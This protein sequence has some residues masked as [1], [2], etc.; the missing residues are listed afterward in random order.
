MSHQ[1]EHY[2]PVT[3]NYIAWVRI[4]SLSATVST[5]I[6]MYYGN[7]AIASN[8]S[9]TATWSAGYNGVWHLHNDFLDASGTGNNG[10]NNG[11]TDV[12]P[13]F[14]ADGQNFTDPNHWIELP[15]HPNIT[16]SF[17]STAWFRSSDVT[18]TGQRIICD[19][20]TNANGCWAISL[21]DPGSGRLRF[22]IR[23]LSVV[24]HDTGN[25]IANNTWY[26][27]AVVFN[28]TTMTKFLYVNGALIVSG[29]VTGTLGTPTGNASI[30]GEVAA[31][32][33]ANR[34][35]GDIDE[36]RTIPSVLSADWIAAEYNNQNSPSGFYTISGQM[37]ATDLCALLPV[38]LINFTAKQAGAN[39]IELDWTTASENNNDYFMIEKS[40][41]GVNW[42][43]IGT[44]DG[45]GNT[46]HAINYHFEDM[47]PYYGNNYYRLKQVDF[48]GAFEYSVVAKVNFNDAQNQIKIF[49]NPVNDYV[50][51]HFASAPQS[52]QIFNHGIEVTN[53]ITP[54]STHGNFLPPTIPAAFVAA[55]CLHFAG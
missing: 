33:T 34:F 11:S 36:V 17:S 28:A 29:T 27:V 39:A 50:N 40:E 35:Q 55:W 26:H 8:P 43:F 44:V 45:H 7:S 37:T 22:Y 38:E 15:S 31:G 12:S 23:G 48:D 21:G 32:E 19:D 46:S 52:F 20:A 9:T 42:N 53:Y 10:T 18:R 13:A 30:G 54:I 24:T 5:G 41:N 47:K 6:H 25:I 1:I 49:P 14:I 4:P 51:I 3:G 2:N 16:G